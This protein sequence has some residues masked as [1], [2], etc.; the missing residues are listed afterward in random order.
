MITKINYFAPVPG[1]KRRRVLAER[2]R[3][4]ERRFAERSEPL[5]FALK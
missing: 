5:C 3:E 1:R 4:T 2:V